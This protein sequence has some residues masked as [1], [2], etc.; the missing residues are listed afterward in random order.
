[1]IQHGLEIA[2]DL[3]LLAQHP[4]VV[5]GKAQLLA[6]PSPSRLGQL[7]H[8]LLEVLPPVGPD[9]DGHEV[10]VREITIVLGFL[11][12][13]L[14]LDFLGFGVPAVGP[15]NDRAARGDDLTLPLDFDVERLLHRAEG[16]HVLDLRLRARLAIGGYGDVGV[17]AQ[18]A[19]G[20]VAACHAGIA[21]RSPKLA[22]ELGGFLGGCDVRLGDDLH[23]RHATAV[24]IDETP[25]R[26]RI[27]HELSRVLLKVEP[28]D[29]DAL[30]LAVAPGQIEV[31]LA[32]D[33]L[34]VL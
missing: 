10:G 4:D 29:A 31:A 14:E 23:Q 2:G 20:H 16:V 26:L 17:A 30:R 13:A 24:E 6:P 8:A 22:H 9:D 15:L 5:V 27:V 7:G 21:Q 1:M 11:F 3:G 18:L 19:L 34:V 32:G 28:P 12:R 33:R 25:A